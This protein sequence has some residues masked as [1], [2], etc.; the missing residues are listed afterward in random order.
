MTEVP[1]AFVVRQK[2]LHVTE[3]VSSQEIYDFAR[4]RLASYKALNG[5]ISFIEEIPRTP[6]GKIQRFKLSQMDQ[7][8]RS[9]TTLLLSS[10]SQPDLGAE[11]QRRRSHVAREVEAIKRSA[12]QGK[13]NP[14]QTTERREGLRRSPRWKTGES[15]SSAILSCGGSQSE[16]SMS[17]TTRPRKTQATSPTSA[18]IRKPTKQKSVLRKRM[19]RTSPKE[20]FATA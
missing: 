6:S 2:R 17:P 11:Q 3:L 1:R 10:V 8:R 15:L 13:E 4:Q 16:R 18:K 9:I 20:V 5:G 7:Y 12:L 19:K 14:D